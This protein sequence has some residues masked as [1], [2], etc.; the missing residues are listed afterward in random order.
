MRFET[1]EALMRQCEQ[2][3]AGAQRL[4]AGLY[5]LGKGVPKDSRQAYFW[6]SRSGAGRREMEAVASL[7]FRWEL[8]GGPRRQKGRTFKRGAGSNVVQI[9]ESRKAIAA[10]VGNA[11]RQR[12]RR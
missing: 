7:R 11:N 1:Q 10:P 6:L 3:D 9:F 5:L 4:L 2:G 8:A 12:S